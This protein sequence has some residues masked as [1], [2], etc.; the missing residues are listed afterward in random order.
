[1][2]K[3][4]IPIEETKQDYNQDGMIGEYNKN[5][6]YSNIETMRY[7][8]I[9]KIDVSQALSNYYTIF[10]FECT[11]F[12]Y[13]NDNPSSMNPNQLKDFQTKILKSIETLRPKN[14][15]LINFYKQFNQLHANY[16]ANI[17]IE[18]GNSSKL[19]DSPSLKNNP[20]KMSN[21]NEEIVNELIMAWNE[22][23][24]YS[25]IE[26]ENQCSI[27]LSQ[28]M[29]INIAIL[30]YTNYII[31]SDKNGKILQM[32]DTQNLT[33]ILMIMIILNINKQ[34]K[35]IYT[36]IT[37]CN[38]PQIDWSKFQIRFEKNLPNI[39]QL[40]I[41]LVLFYFR[42]IKIIKSKIDSS[43]NIIKGKLE[44]WMQK[45]LYPI[46]ADLYD[47]VTR[48]RLTF[49]NISVKQCLIFVGNALKIHESGLNI[50]IL[51]YTLW[52]ANQYNKYQNA[53]IRN[54][55]EYSKLINKRNVVNDCIYLG[56]MTTNSRLKLITENTTQ[57][58]QSFTTK[59]EKKILKSRQTTESKELNTKIINKVDTQIKNN[60]NKISRN[61]TND[62][63]SFHEI[64]MLFI[65]SKYNH[66]KC[67][68]ID[69]NGELS[70]NDKTYI[71][72]KNRKMK[73]NETGWNVRSNWEKLNVP[74]FNKMVFCKN[75]NYGNCEAGCSI[76]ILMMILIMYV[77][78]DYYEMLKELK[79]LAASKIKKLSNVK[80]KEYNS[81]LMLIK[82][83]LTKEIKQIIT[84]GL[85]LKTDLD[86][87]N[88]SM[89]ND[90]GS[91]RNHAKDKSKKARSSNPD[92]FYTHEWGF[93]VYDKSTKCVN[94]SGNRRK[95]KQANAERD[96]LKCYYN[97]N[98]G[99]LI[100]SNKK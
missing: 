5:K 8:D 20:D 74:Q 12:L 87:S 67:F 52:N 41:A 26:I 43:Q 14:T 47:V 18:F 25:L 49:D 29:I 51:D 62:L 32:W 70:K 33:D 68:I 55:I 39:H 3:W 9:K 21:V 56:I 83:Q 63:D 80:E 98:L 88:I 100:K 94:A 30:E 54:E 44:T 64:L 46:F 15:N 31:K 19:I 91:W 58:L 6:V 22:N 76:S 45:K 2:S 48:V 57:I 60:I 24:E 73:K 77:N 38:C 59:K 66:F 27:L 82:E 1:M 93:N 16:W 28:N 34:N 99:K 90:T 17:F 96:I 71:H 79:Q 37:Q 97:K 50:G 13:F 84:S 11:L 35:K 81:K 92:V 61:N 69:C 23:D 42:L 95:R 75:Y 86:L 65:K 72:T 85:E 40:L 7:E 4:Y 89:I 78:K 36:F 10:M 53:K